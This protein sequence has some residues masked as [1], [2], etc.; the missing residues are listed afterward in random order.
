MTTVWD[1]LR[2]W[3]TRAHEAGDKERMRLGFVFD[4][5]RNTPNEQHEKRLAILESGRALAEQLREPRLVI[6]FELWAISTLLSDL[7]DLQRALDKAARAALEVAKPLF[8]G[9]PL[10]PAINLKLAQVYG[11]LDPIAHETAIRAT[12]ELVRRDSAAFDDFQPFLALQ[13]AAFLDKIDDPHALAATSEAIAAAQ[14]C[15][16]DG[17]EMRVVHHLMGALNLFCKGLVASAIKEGL[18]EPVQA[19]NEYAAQ[20]E[21]CARLR[22]YNSDIAVALMWR[23]LAA[24]WEGDETLAARFYQ[25]AFT[26]QSRASAS[27]DDLTHAALLFHAA[28]RDWDAALRL[29]QSELRDAR[30]RGRDFH[31]TRLRIQ[32]LEFLKQAHRPLDREIARTRRAARRL[33]SCA[34]WEAQL[35]GIT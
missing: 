27:Q 28:A 31:E 5:F 34:H 16:A 19:L 15:G 18:A 17:N 7:R 26:A 24:R 22:E 2:E 32:K 14:R 11:N 12:F 20:A 8:D 3:R 35:D 25:E 4:E 13:W 23:A 9:S 30:A 33:K 6:F 10:R 1:W 29:C 21:S